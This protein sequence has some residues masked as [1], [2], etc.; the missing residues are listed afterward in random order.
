MLMRIGRHRLALLV[1]FVILGGL[2]VLWSRHGSMSKARANPPE[3]QAPTDL[4]APA[5]A[6]VSNSD[7]SQRVVAYIFGT[8]A[9]TRENLGEY[10]IQR[11]GADRLNNLVNKMIIERVC[12]EKGLVVTEAEIEAELAESTTRMGV[13]LKDFETKLLKPRNKTLYEWK[14]DSLRPELL[15]RKFCRDRVQAT[16]DDLHKAFDAYYGEKVKCRI[17]L[18]PKDQSGIAWKTYAKI[19]DS[20]EEFQRTARTQAS[21]QLAAKGGEVQPMGHNT[22]GN[23]ALEKAAFSLRPGEVSQLIETPE[24][25]VVVKCDARVPPQTDK[26]LETERAKLTK[27]VIERKLTLEIPK[28]F[29][30]LREKAQPKMMLGNTISEEDLKREVRQELKGDPSSRTASP[31]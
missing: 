8:V 12:Q 10:L 29:A 28:V 20:E 16:E 1:G 13:T 18:W 5:S 26:H 22:T 31:R 19:R 7:Y 2:A 15:M 24:G 21:Q 25:L 6:Q 27:E 14:E 11:M 3:P 23:D 9:I 30:E 17:I 4:G